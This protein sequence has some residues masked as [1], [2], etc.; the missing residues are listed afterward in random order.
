MIT[1]YELSYAF[2]HITF[3]RDTLNKQVQHLIS[4]HFRPNTPEAETYKSPTINRKQLLLTFYLLSV[5]MTTS[6]NRKKC[7]CWKTN[8]FKHILILINTSFCFCPNLKLW[9]TRFEL[10]TG[11]TPT[12]ERTVHAHTGTYLSLQNCILL[13][14]FSCLQKY[15]KREA[16][17]SVH[18]SN[19]AITLAVSWNMIPFT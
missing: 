9:V 10:V 12:E 14:S 11:D 7:L 4:H 16:T 18:N 19:G 1:L 15:L 6:R 8:V 17:A 2:F 5:F 13:L 3:A